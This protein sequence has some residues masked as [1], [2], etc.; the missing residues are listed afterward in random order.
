MREVLRQRSLTRVRALLGM[1][2]WGV[3][4]SGGGGKVREAEDEVDGHC[5]EDIKT[6]LLGAYPDHPRY[7]GLGTTRTLAEFESSLC[8][9]F[10]AREVRHG[11][12]D[13]AGMTSPDIVAAAAAVSTTCLIVRPLPL[14]FADDLSDL[15]AEGMGGL[16]LGLGGGSGGGKDRDRVRVDG[17]GSSGGAMSTKLAALDRVFSF[18]RVAK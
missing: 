11:A 6:S 12:R 10:A 5:E 16:G 8:V 2:V 18:L 4:G 9:G 1:G 13:A 14:V 7:Y 3:G 15:F 17:V